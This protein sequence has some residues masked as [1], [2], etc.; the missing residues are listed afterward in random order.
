MLGFLGPPRSL[1]Q[2]VLDPPWS[3]R[4]Q[5]YEPRLQRHGVVNADGFG[6]GW[7]APEVRPEPVCYRSDRP[8]W[9]DGS[10]TSL[11]GTV[12]SPAV[13]A[14][15]RS[16]TAPAPSDVS[17]AHPFTAGSWLF[18]HNGVVFGF[19]DGVGT[20][21]RRMVSD[22][23]EPG[24][25]GAADSEVL[26][27]LVLDTV[28]AGASPAD[29]L[30]DVVARVTAESGGRLNLLLTD[31]RQMVATRWGE[32]L[33]VLARDSPDGC[34]RVVASE[35]SDDETGWQ[36]VPDRSLV[37]VTADDLAVVSLP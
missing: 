22:R 32:D 25:V 5:S 4:R 13:V 20:R 9:S 23:R 2:L 34:E 1:E 16:A 37:T 28:D 35:P 17:G 24:I 7:Y 18:A 10:F 15:V 11:A 14:S 6:V 19:R 26:F 36:P 12:S 21:L 30:A 29:A 33:H 3:L 27:A 8:I 31:G